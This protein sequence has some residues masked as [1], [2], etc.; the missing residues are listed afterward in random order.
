[1][2]ASDNPHH[3][4]VYPGAVKCVKERGLSESLERKVLGDNALVFYGNRLRRILGA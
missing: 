1:M 2:F 3:D 4:A